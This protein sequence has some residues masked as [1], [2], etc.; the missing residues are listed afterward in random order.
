MRDIEAIRAQV[1]ANPNAV[2][3]VWPT[4]TER[5]LDDPR[6]ALLW[7]WNPSE[8]E[9]VL[10]LGHYPLHFKAEAGEPVME[11]AALRP[12]L[13]YVPRPPTPTKMKHW[14]LT[15]LGPSVWAVSPSIHLPGT[16]HGY[17]TLCEVP[18]PAPW[19]K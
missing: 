2:L 8:R 10:R 18:D 11:E 12:F 14:G 15:K 9:I 13:I 5:F 4:Y 17:V 3:F 19:E 7:G 6:D 1:R 16:F